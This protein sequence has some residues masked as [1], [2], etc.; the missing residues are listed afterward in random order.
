M[1]KYL[2]GSNHTQLQI[3]YKI[4]DMTPQLVRDDDPYNFTSSW[5]D[6]HI[7]RETKIVSCVKYLKNI[8]C[9]YTY[10]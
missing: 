2:K 10:V 8:K 6:K 7:V 3:D 1:N 5:A 9:L 4:I